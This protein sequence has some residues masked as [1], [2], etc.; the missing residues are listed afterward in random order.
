MAQEVLRVTESNYNEG[1]SSL[2]DLLNASS[3]LI[4]AQMNYINA[5]SSSVKACIDLKK[6]DGT[7]TDLTK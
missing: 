1:I 4:Q 6:A 3:S 7:I 2:S 5:L